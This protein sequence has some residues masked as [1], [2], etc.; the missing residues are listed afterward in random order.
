MKF[1]DLQVL[2][3]VK[4]IAIDLSKGECKNIMG[5]MFCVE[6]PFVK[7]TLLLWFNKKFK[8]QNLKTPALMKMVYKQKKSN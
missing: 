4:D 1:I 3:Q 5:Q 2:N 8:S 7:K 6:S